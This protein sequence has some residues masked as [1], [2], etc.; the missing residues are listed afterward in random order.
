MSINPVTWVDDT[1]KTN[2]NAGGAVKDTSP[3]D[4]LPRTDVNQ[5]NSAPSVISPS[6]TAPI[7]ASSSMTGAIT[8]K[9]AYNPTTGGYE[10][11]A[12]TV[13][14]NTEQFSPD[15]KQ[16][17][18]E[19]AWQTGDYNPNAFQ[20]SQTGTLEM[21][22]VT[23]STQTPLS[24]AAKPKA[25]I[26]M[27]GAEITPKPVTWEVTPVTWEVKTTDQAATDA[28]NGIYDAN[29]M[30]TDERKW[31]NDNIF[32]NP[33]EKQKFLG[34]TD[35][36]R[37]NYMKNIRDANR[38]TRD[39]SLAAEQ[40]KSAYDSEVAM[41]KAQFANQNAKM[42][43]NIS[44]DAQNMS[45]IA[46]VSGRLQSRQLQTN[47]S[48]QLKLNQD[49]YNNLLWYQDEYMK[50]L[51]NEFDYKN[52]AAS[53]EYN[54]TMSSIKNDLL[55]KI[56]NLQATWAMNTKSGLLQAQSFIDQAT[57]SGVNAM[58]QY[59]YNLQAAWETVKAMADVMREQNKYDDTITKQMWDGFLYT[60]QGTK[61]MD[62]QGQPL[63]I[64]NSN[65]ILLSKEPIEL[66]DGSKALIYQNPDWTSRTEKIQWTTPAVVMDDWQVKNLAAAISNGSIDASTLKM[67]PSSV[68]TQVLAQI[69]PAMASNKDITFG[70]I[71]TDANG[72]DIMGF[73]DKNTRQ[74]TPLFWGSVWGSSTSNDIP[75]APIASLPN[76]TKMKQWQRGYWC[77][78]FVND[79]LAWTWAA[80][81]GDSLQS[82]VDLIDGKPPIVGSAIVMSLPWKYAENGHVGI[83]MGTDGNG[84]LLVKSSNFDWTHRITTD[85]IS[86]TDPRILWYYTPPVAEGLSPEDA[87]IVKRLQNYDIDPNSKIFSWMWKEA[88]AYRRKIFGAAFQNSNYDMKEYP[89]KAALYKNWTSG[90]IYEN[91]NWIATVTHHIMELEPA[92]SALQNGD[93]Q[94]FNKLWNEGA[95]QFWVAD[96]NNA[97]VIANAVAS[98]MAKVYKGSA[99]PTSDEIAEWRSKI[100]TNLSENQGKGLLK[101]MAKLLYGKITSNA[102]NYY[103]TMGEKPESIFD[104]ESIAFLKKNGVDVSKDFNT[105]TSTSPTSEPASV[106]WTANNVGIGTK[107]LPSTGI[108]PQIFFGNSDAGIG[109]ANNWAG[110]SQYSLPSGS[111][112]WIWTSGS[113]GIGTS[114]A[115]IWTTATPTF[116][117]TNWKTWQDYE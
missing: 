66:A 22:P 107:G 70:K 31:F 19:K 112:V 41:Q 60:S 49:I 89:A 91:N 57:S 28:L 104:P 87:E 10:S 62:A 64:N 74:V 75:L 96:P 82:K 46:W 24:F 109:S 35:Q 79:A 50:A 44:A 38:A 81:F 6:V 92:L 7:S 43:D 12:P 83:V 37:L 80:K 17:M 18:W 23:P 98:E 101:T 85:P 52:T 86:P 58:S 9:G 59:N 116:K 100:A 84:N 14:I 111:S 20:R 108:W 36:E 51:K 67:L 3:W 55:D 114:S 4:V 71:G 72:K 47:I 102:Q 94:K 65:W 1:I 21:K 103:R 88:V 42:L 93:V 29:N 48:N 26:V 77:G 33:Q 5:V 45:M 106:L 8:D 34:M 13:G 11:I 73:I 56:K 69:H 15:E 105:W 27:P 95:T 32:N 54:D 113:V 16:T 30:S 99:S 68:Q 2:Q 53:N 90:K 78:E 117:A 115:G 76:N 110:Y 25:V 39:A 40:R 97:D 63:K 61:M